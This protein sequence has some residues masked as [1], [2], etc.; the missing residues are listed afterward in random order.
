MVPTSTPTLPADHLRVYAAHMALR[1]ADWRVRH[2]SPATADEA[3]A[4]ATAR[5]TRAW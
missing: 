1:V 5:L 2:R 3:I 4:Y